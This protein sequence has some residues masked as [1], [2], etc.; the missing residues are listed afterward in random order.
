MNSYR[1]VMGSFIACCLFMAAC[2]N[3]Q[4]NS[5]PNFNAPIPVNI[6]VIQAE[7]ATYY[8]KYPGTVS[9]LMQVD[10]KPEAEGYL[11]GIFFKEGDHVKK[12]QK[13]YAIEHKIYDASRNVAEANLKVAKANLEQAQADADRY[14]FLNEH[15]AVAKQTLDHALITLQNAKNQVKAA[16]QELIKTETDFGHTSIVAPFDGTIGISNVKI[17]NAVLKGQTILNTISTDNPM[18]VDF[19]VNEK[20]IQ[21]FI[22]MEQQK[23]GDSVFS[24]LM[25]DNSLYYGLGKIMLIDRGVNPQTGTI[26]VR[27]AFPNDSALL[28]AGMSCLV[29][30]KNLDTGAVLLAPSKA[31]IEQMGE[32]FVF[33]AR[34]TL[35][36]NPAATG[37]GAKA[38]SSLHAIQRRVLLGA[39]VGDRVIVRSGLKEGDSVIVDGIQ[40]MRDGGDIIIGKPEMKK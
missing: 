9:A 19:A 32:Y 27:L 2:S 4:N 16:E 36:P 7:K 22:R 14:T 18:A 24:I 40:R 15:D 1:I 20:Q 34:D 38:G 39:P 35:I 29:R 10:L 23:L 26:T 30:V 21:K 25:P 11:T 37:Q 5:A 8:E 6:S 28:R 12:G 33:V 31:L 17:G 3:S 13:L